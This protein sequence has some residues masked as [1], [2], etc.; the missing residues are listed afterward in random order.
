LFVE[1]KV[2]NSEVSSVKED[3]KASKKHLKDKICKYEKKSNERETRI[4][5]LLDYKNTK[6]L[7]EK[8]LK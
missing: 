7:E 6:F 2:L 5:S 4:I 3:L 8:E 1:N